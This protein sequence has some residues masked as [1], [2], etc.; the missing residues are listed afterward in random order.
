[1]LTLPAT[2]SSSPILNLL[3]AAFFSLTTYFYI[4][5]MVED[6][7]YVPKISSRSQQK[8]VVKQLFELW[9]FD[10][11]NFCVPC[12]SRKPLRSKHCRRCGRCVAKHDQYV[13]RLLEID[14]EL[15]TD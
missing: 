1:M 14:L 4:I 8:E 15:T 6:P 2:F 12:M 13:L 9:K 7:G 3:F 10:E 11:E 5:A